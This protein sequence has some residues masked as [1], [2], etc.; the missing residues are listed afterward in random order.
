MLVKFVTSV[1]TQKNSYAMGQVVELD[2]EL[3][4]R[5]IDDGIA[6]EYVVR[7]PQ[8]TL[9]ITKNGT[10]DVSPYH[11]VK[12]QCKK[13]Y[14]TFN[15]NTKE[16]ENEE[17]TA[18]V[19]QG[20]E[21]EDKEFTT[22]FETEEPEGKKCVGWANAKDA[23]EPDIEFPLTPERDMTVYAVFADKEEEEINNDID[24]NGQD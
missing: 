23:A 18:S 17:Y 22:I 19:V 8:G 5:Y 11:F 21:M 16:D 24:N 1:S 15:A 20:D 3:A 13:I 12:V 7:E 2:R 14:V 10:V 4:E 6:F 9:N